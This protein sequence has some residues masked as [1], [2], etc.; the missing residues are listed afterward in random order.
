MNTIPTE[1]L[2]Q[3]YTEK[4]RELYLSSNRIVKDDQLAHDVVQECFTRLHKQDFDKVSDHLIPWLFTV[5]RNLSIRF[6]NKKN[7]FVEIFETD[8]DKIDESRTPSEQMDLELH[9]KLLKKCMRKLTKR[10]RDVLKLRFFK[11]LDYNQSA[12][13]LKTTSGNIGFHQTTAIQKLRKM[14]EKHLHE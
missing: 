14:M 4:H 9:K 12:K 7:R 13:K 3:L 8:Y 1:L 11:D 5:C 2:T 6:L 10:Q